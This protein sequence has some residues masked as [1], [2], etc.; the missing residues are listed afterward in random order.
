MHTSIR[1]I[2][3]LAFLLWPLNR[4][5]TC[6]WDAFAIETICLLTNGQYSSLWKHSSKVRD[7]E[8]TGWME[9]LPSILKAV[10]TDLSPLRSSILIP[11]SPSPRALLL[12]D[13]GH[14]CAP[15]PVQGV[16]W[17]QRT[18]NG[19]RLPASS[20][21]APW[22]LIKT[23]LFESTGVQQLDRIWILSFFLRP[24]NKG[25]EERE[26]EDGIANEELEGWQVLIR[27]TLERSLLNM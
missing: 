26:C 12:A 23:R 6:P 16:N 17:R 4:T 22:P 27:Y 11:H 1:I 7:L 18:L 13:S 15:P 20:M 9:Q 24:R 5:K 14:L 19:T 8:T 10:F 2:R 21:T 3:D 25:E